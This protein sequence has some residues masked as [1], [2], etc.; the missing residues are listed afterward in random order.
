LNKRTTALIITSLLLLTVLTTFIVKGNTASNS[1]EASSGECTLIVKLIGREAGMEG[2]YASVD[3]VC[4]GF[5]LIQNFEKGNGC[6]ITTFE[7]L[8]GGRHLL[9]VY[10]VQ[11][12]YYLKPLTR[13]LEEPDNYLVVF[14]GDGHDE[15]QTHVFK[16]KKSIKTRSLDRTLP[17]NLLARFPQFTE[18]INIL[19]FLK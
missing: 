13:P 18:L 7:S 4:P 14:N 2:A 19:Q 16:A 5:G 11:E 10:L 15:I 6:Y 8:G 3:N 17:F 9:K 12:G 1:F